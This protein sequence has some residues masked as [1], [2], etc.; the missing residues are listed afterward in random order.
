MINQE[1]VNFI[2]QQLHTGLTKEKISEELLSGGW[3][4]QDI[5]EGF[6]AV[7]STD[8]NNIAIKSPEFSS[9]FNHTSILDQGKVHH[10]SKKIFFIILIFFL[11][12]TGVSAYYFK[13]QLMDLPL[14]KDFFISKDKT[15]NV[16][17]MV[18]DKQDIEYSNVYNDP[19]G[20][21]SFHYPEINEEFSKLISETTEK[22]ESGFSVQLI[23]SEDEAALVSVKMDVTDRMKLIQKNTSTE[24]QKSFFGNVDSYSVY[25]YQMDLDTPNTLVPASSS[26]IY[27]IEL[28]VYNNTKMDI[29]VNS[30]IKTDSLEAIKKLEGIVRS[31]KINKDKIAST[32]PIVLSQ[33]KKQQD[34]SKDN[35]IK[36]SLQDL[37]SETMKYATGENIEEESFS[38]SGFCNSVAYKNAVKELAKIVA[39]SCK[40]SINSYALSAPISTGYWCVD[41]THRFDY[42]SVHLTSPP[43]GVTCLK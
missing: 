12:M 38:Y 36:R 39:V 8:I 20:L 22:N 7:S 21:F 31:F 5:A 40:D 13:D 33:S 14:M 23:I 17:Q 10:S 1:L 27:V 37:G 41:A 6:V 3:T 26:V 43:S 24:Y 35:F 28:G 29:V 18:Q 34:A 4:S 32:F 30:L 11:F 19:T 16:V 2:K 42:D 15:Q 9:G 25:K